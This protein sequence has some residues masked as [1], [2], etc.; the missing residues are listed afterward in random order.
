MPSSRM[1]AARAADLDERRVAV[2]PVGVRAF[3][4][5]PDHGQVDGRE[6]G[7]RRTAGIVDERR[8]WA[9]GL[10][11]CTEVVDPGAVDIDSG[12]PA[13]GSAA[14]PVRVSSGSLS[15]R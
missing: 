15:T 13:A 14:G 1:Q 8:W 7:P 3:D 12:P 10:A 4:V 5:D 2:V 9:R 6:G 11:S